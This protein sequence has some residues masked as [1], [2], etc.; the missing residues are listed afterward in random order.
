MSIPILQEKRSALMQQAKEFVESEK[1]DEFQ[2]IKTEIE[3]I[4]QK[5][6]AQEFV[7][8]EQVANAKPDKADV[9]FE[10]RAR[11]EYSIANLIDIKQNKR[12]PGGIEVEYDQEVRRRSNFT[13]PEGGYSVPVFETRAV[14]S[15]ASSAEHALTEEFR[16]MELLMPLKD[17]LIC[18]TLGCRFV[19]AMGES[20]K[21]PKQDAVSVPAW[22]SESGEEAPASDITFSTPIEFK[23]KRF[24]S[25][26]SYSEQL[27]RQSGSGVNI[28][29]IVTGDAVSELAL[30]LE[31][32]I[33]AETAA[34]T[35]SFDPLQ[36]QKTAKTRTSDANGKALTYQEIRDLKLE[37]MTSNAPYVPARS[38]FAAGYRLMDKFAT[39]RL[40][41]SSTDS[42]FVA[43]QD[44]TTLAGQR[45]V[46]SN[47][48]PENNLTRG[49]SNK[50]S[51]L[52]YSSDWSSAVVICS[53]G[54]LSLVVDIYSRSKFGEIVL[55]FSQY[56]D[57]KVVRPEAI[58]YYN[59]IL[60]S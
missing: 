22:V 5:I 6:S 44:G 21:W 33:F 1:L 2:K 41:S 14:T 46:V 49:T 20:L 56:V 28:A 32:R 58:E 24:S 48:I 43:S 39:E 37:C 19:Q 16:P 57:M 53:W 12:S 15:A 9:D 38:G 17:K 60:L 4:D 27:L 59:S 8:A 52:Y 40:V 51:A 34:N 13:D 26:T 29:Q 11:K 50:A 45:A 25:N 30:K 47:L 35:K 31:S 42:V 54:Q 7:D 55:A 23:P 10:T 3:G 18:S 36:R